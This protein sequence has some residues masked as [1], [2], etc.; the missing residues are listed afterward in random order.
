MMAIEESFVLDKPN[1]KYEPKKR[2][3][4]PDDADNTYIP[5]GSS[6]QECVFNIISYIGRTL[7]TFS[8]RTMSIMVVTQYY[9]SEF[10]KVH[11][12]LSQT[13]A[14]RIV[15]QNAVRMGIVTIVSRGVY[16]LV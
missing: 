8:P 4:I 9:E 12:E 16:K 1:R 13:I 11:G 2:D 10:D 3:V 6:R 15:S 14:N 5:S 7:D